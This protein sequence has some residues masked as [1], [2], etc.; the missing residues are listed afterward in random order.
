MCVLIAI[1]CREIL[2][3]SLLPLALPYEPDPIEIKD[4]S[5]NHFTII[6]QPHYR[7]AQWHSHI[8]I[9][10]AII[11]NRTFV[12]GLPKEGPAD[13]IKVAVHGKPPWYYRFNDLP[14]WTYIDVRVRFVNKYG[15]GNV[16]EWIPGYSEWG[17]LLDPV[18]NL[19]NNATSNQSFVL[20][21]E[22][23]ERTNGPLQRYEV[24]YTTRPGALLK[25]W[26]QVAIPRINQF[27]SFDWSKKRNFMDVAPVIYWKVRLIGF[28]N[29]GPF[30]ETRVFRVYPGGILI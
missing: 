30:S 17:R 23:P 2:K 20:T 3:T 7:E 6:L 10:H 28:V 13:T 21:W 18:R 1:I 22:N 29:E 12:R 15:A 9:T 14:P 24:Y 19:H 11:N 26:F 4:K 5:P 27:Y 16:S 8:P 25:N